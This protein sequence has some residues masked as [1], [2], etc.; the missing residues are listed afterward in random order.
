MGKGSLGAEQ[1]IFKLRQIEVL[2]V[3]TALLTSAAVLLPDEIQRLAAIPIGVSLAWLGYS[4]LSERR[5]KK[6]R[7]DTIG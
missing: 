7:D 4:L 3:V 1:L 6:S 5:G 2:K